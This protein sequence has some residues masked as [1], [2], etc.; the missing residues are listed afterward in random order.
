M[1]RNLFLAAAFVVANN[2]TAQV[3]PPPTSATPEVRK[4]VEA[5]SGIWMGPDD[6]KRAWFSFGHF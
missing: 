5:M 4:I 6:C 1:L 2:Q 3:K